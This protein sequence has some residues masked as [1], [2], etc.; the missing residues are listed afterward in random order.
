MRQVSV[1]IQWRTSRDVD[2]GDLRARFDGPIPIR[3]RN[4][5][6]KA[7]EIIQS[8]GNSIVIRH[9]IYTTV[10]ISAFYVYT[11]VSRSFVHWVSRCAISLERRKQSFKIQFLSL[12][13]FFLHRLRSLFSVSFLDN[14]IWLLYTFGCN[15]RI[16][17]FGKFLKS[18]QREMPT[19]FVIRYSNRGRWRREGET[20]RP[21]PSHRMS[22]NVNQ[23]SWAYSL[24]NHWATRINGCM[25]HTYR[26]DYSFFYILTTRFNIYPQAD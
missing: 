10:T 1:S 6:A 16:V 18:Q 22:R 4:T 7:N 13:F 3:K 14:N 8:S 9:C 17:V 15:T 5:S 24:V 25:P 11:I 19:F 23:V 2:F 20:R 12:F 26:H 21:D